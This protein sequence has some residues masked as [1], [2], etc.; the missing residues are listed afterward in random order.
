MHVLISVLG[1]LAA[2]VAVD[3]GMY[4]IAGVSMWVSTIA[5]VRLFAMPKL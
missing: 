1:A 3:L 2:G 5:L 4:A